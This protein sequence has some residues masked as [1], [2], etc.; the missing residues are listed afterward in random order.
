[1]RRLAKLSDKTTN[2]YVASATSSMIDGKNLAL[3]GDKAWCNKCK[4]M[5]G[6]IGTA[7]GWSEDSLFV[8]NG[9]R[10]AC[11]CGNNQVIATSDLFDEGGES[12]QDEMSHK[13]PLVSN[14]TSPN[15][16][17]EGKDTPKK[18]PHSD[19]A[20]KVAEYILGEI[21]A[22]VK[23]ATADTIRFQI[24]KDTYKQRMKEWEALPW[25]L[26]GKPPE[27]DL[28][29]AST[30]WFMAVK[31]GARWDHKP[32]IRD[33]FSSVAVARPLPGSGTNSKSYFHRYKNN[34]YFYDVWSNIH[35]GY[36]GLSVGFSEDWLLLGSTIEQWRTSE[37][38]NA[39]PI[40][41][42]T[43]MKIGMA[44]YRQH[45]K[46]ADSLTVSH[47]INALESASKDSLSESRQPHW[48]WNEDNP[49]KINGPE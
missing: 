43:C 21:K 49:E 16:S 39:D 8:G 10:V 14:I 37:E 42:I 48:C 1:M 26:K 7:R 13:Q 35:Y 12:S 9:D 5:F 6:I 45:G 34:D 41:D 32:K 17:D 25:Y 11:K 18:C 31:T 29:S 47:I 23:S 15:T 24:D 20:I 38:G 4:G 3:N 2:G 28:L 19:G 27:Y 46:Y 40:D 36:V 30:I 22:N 33:L 44:L